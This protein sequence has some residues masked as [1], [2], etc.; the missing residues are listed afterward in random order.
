MAAK[1]IASC[2]NASTICTSARYSF[3][4]V[5]PDNRARDAVDR[6]SVGLFRSR[7]KLEAE[8]SA[9]QR[10]ENELRSRRWQAFQDDLLREERERERQRRELELREEAAARALENE[11]AKQRDET[12][13]REQLAR[14]EEIQRRAHER[15][16]RFNRERWEE[17]RRMRQER[18]ENMR[19]SSPEAMRDLRELI[20][21]R[22]EL[23]IKIWN[24]RHVRRPNRPIVQGHMEKADA[25]MEEILDMM[26]L[27]GDN[28]DHRWTLEEW[29][30][31]EVIRDRIREGGYRRWAENP[32]W[33]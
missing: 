31:I 20:R 9:R 29:E 15:R 6:I 18:Y 7:K 4:E 26:E 13:R 3:K 12:R 28:S 23:D 11:L 32:P 16:E 5:R 25:I 2:S 22:H 19:Q 14:Q 17:L 10:M 8:R 33:E 30:K 27:W 24:L 21:I 1:S